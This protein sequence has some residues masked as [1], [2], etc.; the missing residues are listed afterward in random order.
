MLITM[1]CMNQLKLPSWLC[2]AY[3]ASAVCLVKMCQRFVKFWVINILCMAY[4]A[5]TIDVQIWSFAFVSWLFVHLPI[6]NPQKASCLAW[7]KRGL[8]RGSRWKR[9]C[10]ATKDIVITEAF[11]DPLVSNGPHW[12]RVQQHPLQATPSQE[13]VRGQHFGQDDFTS[14]A[15]TLNATE[16][17]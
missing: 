5:N 8:G 9:A 16:Y 1:S 14:Q 12:G 7:Q 10:V 17:K 11:E 13:G 6:E 15:V 2:M 4:M 3:C